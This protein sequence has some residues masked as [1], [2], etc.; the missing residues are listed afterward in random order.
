MKG[1]MKMN[2]ISVL[3][4]ISKQCNQLTNEK[5]KKIKEIQENYNKKIEEL[6]TA[7]AVNEKMNTGCWEC[8]GTGKVA[9]DDGVDYEGRFRMVKCL[10]CNG[11]GEIKSK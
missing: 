8:S 7:Y 11:T 3:Q 2:L 4:E 1:L 10:K 5:D 9:E 6:K